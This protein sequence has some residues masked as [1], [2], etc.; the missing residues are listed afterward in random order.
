MDYKIL[1]IN[2]GASSTKLGYFLN[3]NLIKDIILRHSYEELKNLK[4]IQ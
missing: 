4:N 2:P 3:D 1:V